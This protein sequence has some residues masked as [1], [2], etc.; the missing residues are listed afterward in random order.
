MMALAPARSGACAKAAD[1]YRCYRISPHDSNRLALVFDP[2]GDDT[3][4]VCAVEIF[5]AGGKTPPNAHAVGQEMFFV[6]K[7]EGAATCDGRV[8]PLRAGDSLL[9]RPG[10]AHEIANTGPGRL[11]CLTVMVPNDGFAELIRNGV[12]AALDDEDLA[13]LRGIGRS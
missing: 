8:L 7:G 13:V 10:A 3:D 12:P 2:I 9:V 11:Y 5:D 1:D 4:F 6:L